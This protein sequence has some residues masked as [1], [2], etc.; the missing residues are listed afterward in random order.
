MGRLHRIE[1]VL[2]EPGC[3]AYR[4]IRGEIPSLDL[5]HPQ[6]P[7]DLL[8]T[9]VA[10]PDECI[11][12]IQSL[13]PPLHEPRMLDRPHDSA[14]MVRDAFVRDVDADRIEL[15]ARH[16]R[17]VEHVAHQRVHVGAEAA[18]E[19]NVGGRI[20]LEKDPPLVVHGGPVLG[21]ERERRGGPLLELGWRRGRQE[22]RR[23]EEERECHD[24]ERGSD[25]LIRHPVHGLDFRVMRG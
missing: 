21:R 12:V 15:A 14:L 6:A 2:R 3:A 22:A 16:V 20:V 8:A 5:V 25:E 13:R 19:L 4:F 23:R 18:L 7:P 1:N 9:C 11:E 10:V 17:E 24:G